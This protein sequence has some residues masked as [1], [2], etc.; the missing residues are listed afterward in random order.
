MRH[1]HDISPEHGTAPYNQEKTPNFQFQF[2]PEECKD[3]N[4]DLVPQILWMSHK[5]MF[6]IHLAWEAR[7]STL[8]SLLEILAKE[9]RQEKNG[10]QNDKENVKRSLFADDIPVSIEL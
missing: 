7:G 5:G 3:W 2:L 8:A 4:T 10:N 9:F 1:I 6:P